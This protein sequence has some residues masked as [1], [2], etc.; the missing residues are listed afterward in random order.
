LIAALPLVWAMEAKIQIKH[1]TQG[2]VDFVP[3]PYQAKWLQDTSRTRVCLK[4]RQVG[5]SQTVA[6]E[7]A[8][9]AVWQPGYTGLI[10]SKD[11]DAAIEVVTYAK[12]AIESA[13]IKPKGL[14]VI[15]DNKTSIE[16]S[17]GSRI[18]AVAASKK[19][20]RSIAASRVTLDEL[21]VMQWAREIQ[22]AISPT[23]STGGS[24]DI[25]F[26]PKGRA[27]LAYEIWSGDMGLGY[28]KHKIHWTQ[29]PAFYTPEEKAAGI[30][31]HLCKWYLE[32]RPNYTEAGWAEEYTCDF[33]TSG[34]PVF[35]DSDIDLMFNSDLSFEPYQM[36]NQYVTF[37]DIGRRHDATVGTTLKL[38]TNALGKRKKRIVFFERFE[39]LPYP[40]IA[41]KIDERYAT[42]PGKHYVESNSIG[43]PVLE[44]CKASIE[45]KF[46][47]GKSKTDMITALQLDLENGTLESPVIPQL[48]TELSAYQW[49]DAALTQDCVISLSGACLYSDKGA[50]IAVLG[51]DG[52]SPT[53]HNGW[54]QVLK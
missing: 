14:T 31:P 32:Q 52:S 53:T 33:I 15:I 12:T 27:N 10:V 46:T 35:K 7:H 39:G 3:R 25:L 41:E 30:P 38:Y 17:N 5:M 45:G 36:N 4:A 18:K 9:A 22:Q 2:Y 23:V 47:S 44:F 34:N 54:G 13:R 24:L 42:Y 29:N 37:W 1:P 49:D 28:S 20:G 8:H 50:K 43:D 51:T 21:A 40:K 11:L 48:K 19:A 16:L 6:V 26:S